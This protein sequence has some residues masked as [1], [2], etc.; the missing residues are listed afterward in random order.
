MKLNICKNLWKAI[1]FMVL[2]G[3]SDNFSARQVKDKAE[4]KAAPAVGLPINPNTVVAKVGDSTITELDILRAASAIPADLAKN[5]TELQF[6]ATILRN[7]IRQ[8]LLKSEAK[9]A[10][11]E[12]NPDVKK[13]MQKAAESV[14]AQA[15]LTRVLQSR[16]TDATIRQRY[17]QVVTQ[18]KNEKEYKVALIIC[19]KEA[20]ANGAIADLKKGKSFKDAAVKHSIL[21]DSVKVKAAEGMFVL[22]MVLPKE[23][24]KSLDSMKKG[25]YSR[26]PI[27]TDS[28]IYVIKL[29]DIRPAKVPSVQEMA[30]HLRTLLIQEQTEV[31]LADLE[32]KVSVKYYN[33]DY[34]REIAAQA[35]MISEARKKKVGA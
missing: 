34:E 21:P 4:K 5:F 31:F 32:K 29:L 35:K 19:D 9:L 17:N 26:D 10:H 18:F 6:K 27:K 33:K 12:Q 24:Q 25:D 13:E 14:A 3:V 22:K 16:V 20:A 1:A 15:Y 8:Y 7:L 11:M 2:F 23:V 30:P 28:G